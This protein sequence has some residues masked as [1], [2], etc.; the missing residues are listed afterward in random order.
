MLNTFWN[1]TE[2]DAMMAMLFQR[3]LDAI[4]ADMAACA[5]RM[6]NHS[7]NVFFLWVDFGVFFGVL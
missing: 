1:S 4:S 3:V 6:E 5:P 7:A 2:I